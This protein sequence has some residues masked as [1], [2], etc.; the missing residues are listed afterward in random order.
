MIAHH[1]DLKESILRLALML[2]R[3]CGP[4]T[5][6]ERPHAARCGPPLPIHGMDMPGRDCYLSS[7]YGT[8]TDD[9]GF[10][11][12]NAESAFRSLQRVSETCSRSFLPPPAPHIS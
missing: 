8:V 4:R 10:A 5:D 7:C 11:I 1:N 12:F 2:R 3:W 9:S 6:Y